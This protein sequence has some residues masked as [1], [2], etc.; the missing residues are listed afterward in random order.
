MSDDIPAGPVDISG[1]TDEE[2]AALNLKVVEAHFHNE[3]PDSIDKA[4]ALYTDD[5]VWEAPNRGLVYTDAEEVKKGYLG[6]FETVHFNRTLSLRRYATRDYV[7][8]DQIA[9][10]SVV[11]DKMPNLGFKVGDRISMRLIHIFEMRNGQIARE[12]AYEMSRPW[13]GPT[14]HDWIRPDAFVV[15]YPDGP[16]FG[17]WER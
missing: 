5:V 7:F 10:L 4:I 17:Q 8:D 15:D 9:D 1:M 13:G 16:H 14:D 2:V 6:I 12:I 11:G 3:T